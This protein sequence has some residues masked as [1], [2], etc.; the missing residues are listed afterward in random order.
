MSVAYLLVVMVVVMLVTDFVVVLVF[1]TVVMVAMTVYRKI[2]S[3]IGLVM[4]IMNFVSID[5]TLDMVFRHKVTF[6]EMSGPVGPRS[7]VSNHHFRVCK[8][9]QMENCGGP[10]VSRFS[11]KSSLGI[12]RKSRAHDFTNI[13]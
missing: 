4:L 12:Q 13:F 9:G 8:T 7:L 2:R 5:S 1:M 11:R 6:I 10:L 3:L